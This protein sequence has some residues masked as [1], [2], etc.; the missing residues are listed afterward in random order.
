MASMSYDEWA[1]EPMEKDEVV[2]DDVVIDIDFIRAEDVEVACLLATDP[3]IKEDVE[4][5]E[6]INEVFYNG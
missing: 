2:V 1:T 4:L 6:K 5:L 3:S